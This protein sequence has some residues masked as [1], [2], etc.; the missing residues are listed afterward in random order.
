MTEKYPRLISYVTVEQKAKV[1]RLAL[2]LSKKEHR[3]VTESEI[4]RNLI[5]APSHSD[6]ERTV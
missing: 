2:S 6:K 3:K 1:K 5:D 4:V